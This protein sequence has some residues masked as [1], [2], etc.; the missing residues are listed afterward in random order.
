MI[1]VLWDVRRN[2]PMTVYRPSI[3]S[4]LHL[5]GYDQGM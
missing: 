2:F 4:E 3:A 5:N 1:L